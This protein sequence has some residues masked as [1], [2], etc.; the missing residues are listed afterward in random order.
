MYA[1][2]KTQLRIIKI[3]GGDLPG[4]KA[5]L[6]IYKKLPGWLCTGCYDSPAKD[7]HFLGEFFM[8]RLFFCGV[9]VTHMLSLERYGYYDQCVLPLPRRIRVLQYTYM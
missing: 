4:Y 5:R 2:K 3:T 7:A 1:F 6:D 8:Y 9:Y